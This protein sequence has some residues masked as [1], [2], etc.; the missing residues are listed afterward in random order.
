VRVTR[1]IGPA[2]VSIVALVVAA[3]GPLAQSATP[4]PR[5]PDVM[6]VASD[7][8]V[9]DAMI[10]LAKI[11]RSDVVYDLGCGDGRILIAAARRTGA[12][13]V[14]IDIDP[15]RIAEATAAARAA[16]VGDKVR[17]VEGDFFDPSIAI[18]D[19]TV[20]TLF[21]LPELNRRLRP[22]LLRDLRP[23]T[24]VVSNS[25]DMGAA[26]APDKTAQ[27]GDFVVYLWTIPARDPRR[28]E[29]RR[30]RMPQSQRIRDH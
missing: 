12:R 26:W 25:F 13:G 3:P 8:L 17:F 28:A 21:L 18:G 7:P 16:G 29:A 19:A 5:R 15:V 1:L 27:A 30:L 10:D 6:F 24:R 22:R 4:P 2:V 20:V 11:T 23:G 9:I 14:G